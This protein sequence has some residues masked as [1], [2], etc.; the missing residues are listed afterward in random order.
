MSVMLVRMAGAANPGPAGPD[1]PDDAAKLAAYAGA[2]ADSIETSLPQ[3]VER[4]ILAV[5]DGA[6]V[7]INAELRRVSAE[8][9]AT[10]AAEEGVA[11][12]ALLGRDV[13]DQPTGPLSLL[14]GAV[15]HPTAVLRATGVARLP[16]DLEAQRLH[17]DDLYD[18]TPG[19]FA[20]ID[21][22]LHEPGLLW[23]AAK[24]HVILARRRREGRR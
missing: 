16:R 21:P 15:R 6:G 5:A 22:A 23:G 8:A 24:A 14:R 1:D 9:G 13:D 3:W 2:L 18:L 20:D 10:A 19:A 7:H 12:R 17:P 4:S 11:I